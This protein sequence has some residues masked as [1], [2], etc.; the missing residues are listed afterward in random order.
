MT[1]EFFIA[2]QLMALLVPFLSL[3]CSFLNFRDEIWKSRV[4]ILGHG[5]AFVFAVCAFVAI[6]CQSLNGQT[7]GSQALQFRLDIAANCLTVGMTFISF[8]VLAFS[9]RY[10][11]GESRR[12]DFLRLLS[13]LSSV[14][15]PLVAADSLIVAALCWHLLS[16]VLSLLMSLRRDAR[17]AAATVF[18][19]HVVSDIFFVAAVSMLL[20]SDVTSFSELPMR[21]SSMQSCLGVGAESFPVT[22]SG[23]VCALLVIA[24]SI[25]S[26]L[27]PFHRWLLATLE[28]PTP[29]SG[30]LHAGVVNVSAVVAYR[31]MPLLAQCPEALLVWGGLAAISA[32]L[33]TASMSAQPDVKRKLV[34]STIGQMGFMSL[35][36]ASGAAAAAIFHVL[37]HGL[38]KCH[39]FLQSGGAVSE[40]VSKRK[41]AHG[42][43]TSGASL[44]EFLKLG[45]IATITVG[46]LCILS[47]MYRDSALTTISVFVAALASL[48]M[49]PAVKRTGFA[50]LTVFWSGLL[51]LAALNLAGSR[52]LDQLLHSR[53]EVNSWLLP[54][55][56]CSFAML[57]AVFWISR[58]TA[59]AKAFYVH[60][61]SGFYAEDIADALAD[62]V[63][64]RRRSY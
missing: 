18:R 63:R 33:G 61:L 46:S 58:K 24:F 5:T 31:M 35:Q 4:L 32:F 45:S 25:K 57:S 56:I 16:V 1:S 37:A 47:G 42:G 19:Y 52:W 48:S 14:A 59:M 7:V 51:A 41:Y 23:I 49:I 38:F 13:L 30:L 10:M 17:G 36:C 11:G 26:A 29:L 44:S 34:Y 20:S 43:E 62:R 54:M 22:T 9:D 53:Y 6:V 12:L 39:M 8:V 21:I 55:C 50:A 2:S 3:S 64:V 15:L 40:G 60:A 28:A 27:F